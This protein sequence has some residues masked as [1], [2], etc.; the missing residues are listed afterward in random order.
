M[1][2]PRTSNLDAQLERCHPLAPPIASTPACPSF[3]PLITAES[4]Y[5]TKLGFSVSKAKDKLPQV[6]FSLPLLFLQFQPTLF[7]GL[8]SVLSISSAGCQ[9]TPQNRALLKTKFMSLF[10]A[11]ILTQQECQILAIFIITSVPKEKAVPETREDFWQVFNISIVPVSV[12]ERSSLPD[13]LNRFV[14]YWP[15]ADNGGCWRLCLQGGSHIQSQTTM[16]DGAA[17]SGGRKGRTCTKTDP[18][19][20]TPAHEDTQGYRHIAP[21]LREKLEMALLAKSL[22]FLPSR[23]CMGQR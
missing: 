9:Q 13:P 8:C 16:S 21:D 7:H 6:L 1:P 14:M 15:H 18:A 5:S 3:F 10:S 11:A 19:N 17:G 23:P 4:K 20:L 22:G 2:S 12:S